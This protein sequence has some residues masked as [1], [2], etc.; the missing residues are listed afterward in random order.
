MFRDAAGKRLQTASSLLLAI[1]TLTHEFKSAVCN[2]K[3]ASWRGPNSLVLGFS[4]IQRQC[5]GLATVLGNV[6]VFG[7]NSGTGSNL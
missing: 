7:G 1:I 5:H 6:Y 4:P 3:Q 2:S